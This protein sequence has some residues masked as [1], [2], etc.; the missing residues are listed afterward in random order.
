MCCLSPRA[1]VGGKHFSLVVTA[2]WQG[3]AHR[4]KH[5]AY[6]SVD[7][8]GVQF[9]PPTNALIRRWKKGLQVRRCGTSCQLPVALPALCAIC[10][11][12]P[13]ASG[14]LTAELDSEAD[15]TRS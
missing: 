10:V 3:D 4:V 11:R 9:L 5:Y 12:G 13:A 1:F 2:H 6:K 7:S 8:S 14:A 15:G